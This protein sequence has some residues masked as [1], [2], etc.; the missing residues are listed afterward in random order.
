[1]IK[2]GSFAT[3]MYLMALDGSEEPMLFIHQ[4]DMLPL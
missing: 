3:S 1:M 4:T 2:P